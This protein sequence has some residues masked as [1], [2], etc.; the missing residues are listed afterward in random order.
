VIGN[1]GT[2]HMGMSIHSLIE[3]LNQIKSNVY[4]F[5]RAYRSIYVED[6]SSPARDTYPPAIRVANIRLSSDSDPG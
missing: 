5:V 3:S 6:G 1:L 2:A 4:R